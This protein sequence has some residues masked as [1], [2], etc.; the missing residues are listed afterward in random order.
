VAGQDCE[1]VAEQGQRLLAVEDADCYELGKEPKI[2]PGFEKV[3]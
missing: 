3:Q 1:L 2:D